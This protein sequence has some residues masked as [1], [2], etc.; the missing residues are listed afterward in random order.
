MLGLIS[1]GWE[2]AFS[3]PVEGMLWQYLCGHINRTCHTTPKRWRDKA[4]W[5][6]VRLGDDW[7]DL[8]LYAVRTEPPK[9]RQ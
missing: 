3:G 8:Q 2:G 5:A 1:I 7:L 4:A 9:S 6:M